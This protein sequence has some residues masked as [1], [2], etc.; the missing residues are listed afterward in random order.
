[1]EP[2]SRRERHYIGA[3]AGTAG[4]NEGGVPL[5]G[6]VPASRIHLD[7]SERTQPGGREKLDRPLDRGWEGP[8]TQQLLCGR[9][10]S[11]S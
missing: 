11:R 9:N 6:F 7:E 1:M 5:R 8:K 4:T 2:S 3:I 10:A